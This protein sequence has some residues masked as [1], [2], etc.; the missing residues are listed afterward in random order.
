MNNEIDPTEEEY[1]RLRD[2]LISQATEM[3]RS[4]R[5]DA[6]KIKLA[7]QVYLTGGDALEMSPLELRDY[8]DISSPGMLEEAG[9]NEEEMEE[10][11][12]IF[13]EVSSARYSG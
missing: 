7:I 11:A 5:G 1:N 2:K 12:A 6:S 10:A 4:A 3:L 13:E 9:Y 8:F